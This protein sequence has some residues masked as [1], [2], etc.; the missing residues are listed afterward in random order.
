MLCGRK[1]FSPNEQEQ[2]E[3]QYAKSDNKEEKADVNK[4]SHPPTDN[5]VSAQAQQ[6][7]FT[8]VWLSLFNSHNSLRLPM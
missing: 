3:P 2:R 8:R 1:A 4:Q 6:S 7:L 5:L